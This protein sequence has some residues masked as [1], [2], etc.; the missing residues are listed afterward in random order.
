MAVF[1]PHKVLP[2]VLG[3]R[4]AVTRRRLKL[5]RRPLKLNRPRLKLNRRRLKLNR[6][7]FMANRRRLAGNRRGLAADRQQLLH[8]FGPGVPDAVTLFVRV[9]LVLKTAPAHRPIGVGLRWGWSRT[10]ASLHRPCDR[11]SSQRCDAPVVPPLAQL[12]NAPQD[13][14]WGCAN[15]PREP[16]GHRPLTDYSSL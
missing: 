12:N 8:C 4:N 5:D 2:E 15:H 7:L 10:P 3:G 11:R 16:S 1:R 14:A 6:R 9:F 13:S